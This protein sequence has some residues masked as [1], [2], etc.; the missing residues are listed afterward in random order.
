MWESF[1]LYLVLS[2]SFGDLSP[3]TPPPSNIKL[4]QSW[5]YVHKFRGRMLDY[6]LVIHC[7]WNVCQ[8]PQW[9]YGTKFNP[10]CY[11]MHWHRRRRK[12][13]AKACHHRQGVIKPE[14]NFQ[15]SGDY[16]FRFHDPIPPH[17]LDNLCGSIDFTSLTKLVSKFQDKNGTKLKAEL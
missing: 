4:R 7:R 12:P 6:H 1:I 16:H 5:K 2:M 11:V 13:K 14:S 15:L 17:I 9:I 8:S 10:P 3:S